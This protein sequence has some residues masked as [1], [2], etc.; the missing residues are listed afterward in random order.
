MSAPKVE[1]EPPP[2]TLIPLTNK[3]VPSNVK[4]LL[5]C[6]LPAVPTVTTLPDVKL[7]TLVTPAMFTL[8]KFVCPSTSK[9]PLTSTVT[10]VVTPVTFND[11]VVE[12]LD[13][14]ISVSYTHLTL[15]TILRV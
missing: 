9:S 14:L 3:F 1:V 10:A 7:A 4:L 8:S 2:V 5:S 12:E 15:P 13:T 6:N 11:F